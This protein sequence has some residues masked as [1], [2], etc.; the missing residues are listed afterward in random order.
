MTIIHAIHGRGDPAIWRHW[1]TDPVIAISLG[2]VAGV[3][4]GGTRAAWTHAGSGRG[5]RRWQV[6]CFAGGMIVLV[7]ALASPLDALAEQLFSAHMTQHVLLAIV[8]PPLIVAGAPL[9]AALWLLP[10]E[11]RKQLVQ[12]MKRLRWPTTL[13]GIM[14]APALAWA[15]HAVAMWIWHLPRLYALALSNSAIHAAEH[16]SF[17]GTA[18]LI[19]WG[20]IYPRRS[21]RAAYALGI[22]ALFLTMMQSGALGA[23]L[24]LSHR[25]WFPVHAAGEAQWGLAPLEDQQL[26]GLIMWVVGG[27][28]YLAAMSA[29]FLAWMRPGE[30]RDAPAAR[31]AAVIAPTGVNEFD[32]TRSA[33]CDT[34]A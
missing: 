3:Y 8:A 23:L 26:A 31:T 28:L 20:V 29:L 25:I 24:T 22:G 12:W 27:L 7:L 1:L 9:T 4:A 34:P 5:V 18:S 19:W 6:W 17:V 16:M 21:R 33:R 30:R 32:E 10:L 2:A 11:T 13:W 15:I 14:T